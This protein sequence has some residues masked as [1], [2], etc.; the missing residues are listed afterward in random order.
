VN[1]LGADATLTDVA[2]AACT[3]VFGAIISSPS[4]I[5]F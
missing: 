3:T 1:E 5:A 2:F 4:S